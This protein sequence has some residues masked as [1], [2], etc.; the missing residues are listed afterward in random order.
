MKGEIGWRWLGSKIDA[1]PASASA[2]DE[3]ESRAVSPRAIVRMF[4]SLGALMSRQLCGRDY[5]RAQPLQQ[6]IDGQAER[7]PQEETIDGQGRQAKEQI[8]TTDDR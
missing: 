5:S 2:G 6:Q 8:K 3:I 1:K 7:V 4:R